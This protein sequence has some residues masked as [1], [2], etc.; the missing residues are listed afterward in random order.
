MI[1]CAVTPV[2]CAVFPKAKQAAVLNQPLIVSGRP[3]P[4]K[5]TLPDA[6]PVFVVCGLFSLAL[7]PFQFSYLSFE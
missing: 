1:S 6:L 7:L 2:F 5:I 4:T 3:P